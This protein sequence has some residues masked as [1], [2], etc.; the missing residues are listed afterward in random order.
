MKLRDNEPMKI[1][2]IPDVVVGHRVHV[3]VQLP[4]AIEVHVRHKEY[5]LHHPSHHQLIT[6]LVELY[7][8]HY[9]SSSVEHQLIIIF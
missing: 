2:S 9:K 3:D 5:A 4:R 1:L 8:G 7:A 6:L